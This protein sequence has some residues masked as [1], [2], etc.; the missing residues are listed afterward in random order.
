MKKEI[1]WIKENWWNIVFWLVFIICIFD[2]IGTIPTWERWKW[3]YY[4]IDSIPSF[5]IIIVLYFVNNH[6][7]LSNISKR[8]DKLEK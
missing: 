6:M 3:G 1:I 7:W 8:L 4:S 5:V 2:L